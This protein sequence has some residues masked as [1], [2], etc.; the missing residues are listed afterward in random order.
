[1]ELLTKDTVSVFFLF[2]PIQQNI[3]R[4]ETLKQLSYLKNKPN[5]DPGKGSLKILGYYQSNKVKHTI[6]IQYV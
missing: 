2:S 6:W 4:N 3:M 1:M 5:D